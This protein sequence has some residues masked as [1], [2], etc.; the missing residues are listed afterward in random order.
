MSLI[1]LFMSLT[2][3]TRMGLVFCATDFGMKIWEMEWGRGHP[4]FRRCTSIIWELE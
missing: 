1:I 2:I 3:F 4:N